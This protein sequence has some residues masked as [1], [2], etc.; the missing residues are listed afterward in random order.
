M[1]TKADLRLRV[2]RKLALVSEG[3]EPSA[4]QAEVVD[5]VIDDEHAYLQAQGIAA[6]DLTAIPDGALRGLTDYIAGRVAPQM[7]DAERAGAYTSFVNI[8]ERA[9]RDFTAA[10]ASD[11]PTRIV[12]F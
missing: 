4:Y 7:L 12:M 9:L 10:L 11:R 3:Q 1:A 2:L 5:T 6:W 8:G